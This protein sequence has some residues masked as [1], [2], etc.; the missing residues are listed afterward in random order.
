MVSPRLQALKRR[1]M[2][3]VW[4]LSRH[5]YRYAA[6]SYTAYRIYEHPWL[7]RAMLTAVWTGAKM[8]YGIVLP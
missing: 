8:A 1:R 3:Q 5:A 6:A 2:E 7:A 4:L